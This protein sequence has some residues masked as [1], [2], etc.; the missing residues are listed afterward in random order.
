MPTKERVRSFIAM[1]ERG[2]L[3][4][5]IPAFYAEDMTAQE[6]QEPP[7]VGRPAQLANE[8]QVLA[9][10][11]VLAARALHVA[12]DG[13]VVAIHWLFELGLADGTEVRLDEVALQIWRG[14]RIVSEQ[15]FYDPAQRRPSPPIQR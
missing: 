4:E 12:V 13:D 7:R 2:E 15:Y 9:R 11:R 10:S 1:V 6:N 8:R 5:S 3:L 14:D